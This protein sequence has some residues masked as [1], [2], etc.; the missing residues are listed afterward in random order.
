ML[1]VCYKSVADDEDQRKL[2]SYQLSEMMTDDMI[3]MIGIVMSVAPWTEL[4]IRCDELHE[5]N[6]IRSVE[7]NRNE[8][9]SEF[10]WR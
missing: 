10:T 1:K 3:R 8:I 4:D 2:K 5:V 9:S 6:E 7:H